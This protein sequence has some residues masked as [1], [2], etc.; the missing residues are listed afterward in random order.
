MTDPFSAASGAVGIISLG[1][2]VC[3]GLITY[4][5]NFKAFDEDIANIRRKSE[6]LQDLLLALEGPLRR[7]EAGDGNVSAQ[8]RGRVLDCEGGL[9]SLADAMQKYGSFPA[10]TNLE[11]KLRLLGKKTVYPFKKS[12][13]REL[14][15]TLESLQA[16]IQLAV[17]CLT[18][19]V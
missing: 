18:L 19:Y 12:T 7:A 10:P 14:T 1:I 2:Q 5:S 17:T 11:D 9:R 3:Q 4:C 13:L 6:G 8:V 16:N 15:T